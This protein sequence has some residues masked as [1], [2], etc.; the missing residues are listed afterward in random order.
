M[1]WFTRNYTDITNHF[2]SSSSHRLPILELNMYC[3]NI[4]RKE[5]HEN[6][7]FENLYRSSAQSVLVLVPRSILKQNSQ[8]GCYYGSVDQC[9][10][11]FFVCHKHQPFSRWHI[12]VYSVTK[13]RFSV[14]FCPKL[15][16]TSFS[17]QLL[18]SKSRMWEHFSVAYF[19]SRQRRPVMNLG[20]ES[21]NNVTMRRYTRHPYVAIKRLCR[22]RGHIWKIK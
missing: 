3:S 22:F 17:I 18:R 1:H 5:Y 11:V 14:V 8:N 15:L 10:L 7:L 6:S 21:R 2:N 20:D 16:I 9:S 19:M 13:T 12:L 4:Q